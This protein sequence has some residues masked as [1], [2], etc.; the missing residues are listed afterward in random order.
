ML[1]KILS[2]FGLGKKPAPTPV[3]VTI[4]LPAP[5]APEPPKVEAPK[6]EAAPKKPRKPRKPKA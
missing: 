2:F 3:E 5:K 4:D 6:A 1:D